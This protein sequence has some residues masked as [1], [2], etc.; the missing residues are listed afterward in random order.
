MIKNLFVLLLI[1]TSLQAISQDCSH[2]QAYEE[3]D[4]NNVKAGLRVAGDLW[5]DGSGQGRYIVPKAAT[6]S[7]EVSAI[8]SGGLWLAGTDPAG[9]LKAAITQYPSGNVTDYWAGPLDED[10][11]STAENCANWDRFFKVNKSKVNDHRQDFAADGDIDLKREQIYSWPA[12]GNQYFEEYNGFE[13]PLDTDLAPFKDKNVNGIYEPDL[14]DYP[15]IKGD[16]SI[17]W[18]FND[19]GNDHLESGADKLQAE[20]QVMAYAQKSDKASIN[21]TTFYEYK[22]INKGVDDIVDFR[23]GLWV[24]PD[25]GCYLDD[26]IG[27]DTISNTAFIYNEDALDGTIGDVCP[28]GVNTYFDKIPMV[29]I[30]ILNSSFAHEENTCFAYINASSANEPPGTWVPNNAQMAYNVLRGLWRDGTPITNGGLGYNPGSTDTVKIAFP[31]DPSDPDGWSLCTVD[32]PFQDR[33][34]VLSTG[35]FTLPPGISASI[36]YAVVTVEDVPHPCPSLEPLREVVEEVRGCLILNNENVTPETASA[37]T[38]FPNPASGE[39]TLSFEQYF[40]GGIQLLDIAGRVLLQQNIGSTQEISINESLATGLYIIKAT[41]NTG[42]TSSQ[43]MVIN[44]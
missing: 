42:R 39:F 3:L 43:K 14:G 21:N 33:R 17:W 30:T 15:L 12:N 13:L 36:T 38:L 28:G 1:G 35:G 6:P 37:F 9:N 8:F 10:G 23:I 41:D 19:A 18:V 20:I 34:F 11:E 31:G 32:P 40:S 4:V 26:F 16:Q 2:S 7:A 5:W 22:I 44:Q 25:L 24:D 27:Y 29:G